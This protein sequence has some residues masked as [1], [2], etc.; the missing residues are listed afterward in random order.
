MP[1][2]VNVKGVS[3]KPFETA[4]QNVARLF[5]MILANLRAEKKP[6]PDS[7]GDVIWKISFTLYSEL[8]N[9]TWQMGFKDFKVMTPEDSA[10]FGQI[11][12]DINAR[13]AAG[14]LQTQE[15]SE[16]EEEAAVTERPAG[17]IPQA[18]V[19]SVQTNAVAEQNAKIQI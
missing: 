10:E 15:A 3:V 13:R 16:A 5:Q 12:K 17:S 19:V 4:M 6:M 9:S 8:R 11:L 14:Q 18:Q 1:Y 7:I 2:Y